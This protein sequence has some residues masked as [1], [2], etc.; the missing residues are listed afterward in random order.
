VV[1]IL[2]T[3]SLVSSVAEEAG[4]RGY[5]QVALESYFSA[6]AAILIQALLIAPA[7]ALTQGFVWPTVVFYLLVDTMLG[8]SAYLTRSIV[9]GVIVH[10]AGLLAFFSFIWPE[11]R[12][13]VPIR[14]G[15]AD[16]SFWI[17]IGQVVV[18]GGLAIGAYM[19]LAQ[20]THSSRKGTVD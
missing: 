10:T 15:G 19:R 16:Q 18:F 14:E 7:H 4:F 17:H 9:P 1:V 8:T 20:L 2:A 6:P 5:F 13:R 3:A 12:H 11:D